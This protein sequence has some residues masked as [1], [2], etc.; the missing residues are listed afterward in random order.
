MALTN[1][2]ELSTEDII[3]LGLNAENGELHI[4]VHPGYS[5]SEE[6]GIRKESEGLLVTRY[7][8]QCIDNIIEA[9]QKVEKYSDSTPLLFEDNDAWNRVVFPDEPERNQKL[10]TEAYMSAIIDFVSAYETLRETVQVMTL[11]Q[12]NTPLVLVV[13]KKSLTQE[14]KRYGKNLAQIT[15]DASNILNLESQDGGN[16]NVNG[17]LHEPYSAARDEIEA[18]QLGVKSPSKTTRDKV[19]YEDKLL[20]IERLCDVL[21]TK[22]AKIFGSWINK[23]LSNTEES[24]EL[25]DLPNYEVSG[26]DSVT[27][28]RMLEAAF[29]G[30]DYNSRD[31]RQ[32]IGEQKYS[33][34]CGLI[35]QI[36]K[37]QEDLSALQYAKTLQPAEQLAVFE[38]TYSELINTLTQIKNLYSHKHSKMIYKEEPLEPI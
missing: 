15:G 17:Y 31:L 16:G 12:N 25:T 29:S 8:D 4:A 20:A 28:R 27:E 32:E 10:K 24:I 2:L 37:N 9:M 23:C 6:L 38:T 34:F 13:P 7:V 1:L 19:T 30:Y 18:K 36:L 33:K 35:N 5:V 21:G 22:K 26:N 11:A 3:D 14:S